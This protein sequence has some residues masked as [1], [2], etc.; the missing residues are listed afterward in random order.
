MGG[1]NKKKSFPEKQCDEYSIYKKMLFLSV[2]THRMV[3]NTPFKEQWALEI[4]TTRGRNRLFIGLIAQ[5]V[6]DGAFYAIF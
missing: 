5:N 1:N 2:S 3:Q 4:C 6:S